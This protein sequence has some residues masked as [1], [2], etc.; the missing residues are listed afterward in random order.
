M[1]KMIKNFNTKPK[2]LILDQDQAKEKDWNAHYIKNLFKR[3]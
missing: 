2:N 1:L 3:K